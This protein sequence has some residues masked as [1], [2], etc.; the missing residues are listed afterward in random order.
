MGS[1]RG[2]GRLL[3]G[4]GWGSQGP[5]LGQSGRGKGRNGWGRS[6]GTMGVRDHGESG[7]VKG[8]GDRPGG[9]GL[10]GT[11]GRRSMAPRGYRCWEAYH[12]CLYSAKILTHKKI[13]DV[14]GLRSG[15][16]GVRGRRGGW[17]GVIDVSGVRALFLDVRGSHRVCGCAARSRI[18]DDSPGT[19][20]GRG[21]SK[22]TE[23][24]LKAK[25]ERCIEEQQGS[26][27]SGEFIFAVRRK[28]LVW[29]FCFAFAS[30]ASGPGPLLTAAGGGGVM[31]RCL[32]SAR[33]CQLDGEGEQ[34]LSMGLWA[35]GQAPAVHGDRSLGPR[36]TKIPWWLAQRWCRWPHPFLPA[37]VLTGPRFMCAETLPSFSTPPPPLPHYS[38]NT[39]DRGKKRGK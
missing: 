29:A 34:T 18:C 10:R 36:T 13:G 31:F 38:I 2:G 19:K 37:L 33:R 4:W 26:W 35:H 8:G 25:M 20:K 21:G 14:G 27:T 16:R 3:L 22:K 39:S 11:A 9:W 6:A 24:V 7:A 30:A 15:A 23:N 17:N 28:A 1:G 32:R 5:G 12:M